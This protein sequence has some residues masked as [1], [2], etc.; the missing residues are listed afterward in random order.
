MKVITGLDWIDSE[1]HYPEKLIDFCINNKPTLKGCDVVDYV[2]V[3]YKCSKQ[4]LIKSRNKCLVFRTVEDLL[5]L[6]IK[7]V[8]AFVFYKKS[9][10]LLRVPIG[11]ENQ[12]D[13]H[14]TI[15]CLWALIDI[16]K[17]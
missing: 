15:L 9:R 14:G 6:F 13:L 3:L 12:A 8:E 2:Y 7:A 5:K 4:T 1:I 10:L 11:K 16:R 17:Q